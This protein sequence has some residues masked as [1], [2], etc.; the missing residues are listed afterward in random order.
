MP[1][2]PGSLATLQACLQLRS[3]LSTSMTTLEER[4]QTK[5]CMQWSASLC[6]GCSEGRADRSPGTVAV[7][8]AP[9]TAAFRGHVQ[10]QHCNGAHCSAPAV[11]RAAHI[12]CPGHSHQPPP[13]QPL[14][15]HIQGKPCNGAHCFA[16]AVLRAAQF[17]RRWQSSPPRQ[18][19]DK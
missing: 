16:P 1:D 5:H 10:K 4:L 13:Q 2:T 11:L 14:E 18:P 6:A 19:L 3:S 9:S 8:S 7:S 12:D 17:H 15:E